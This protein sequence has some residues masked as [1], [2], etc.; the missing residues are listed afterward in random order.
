MAMVSRSVGEGAA[1]RGKEVGIGFGHGRD[2]CATA[3][4][5]NR[6]GTECH[7]AADRLAAW[8]HRTAF[9]PV[10]RE[11]GLVLCSAPGWRREPVGSRGR[12]APSAPP[13]QAAPRQ[14][15]PK[16]AGTEARARPP[17]AATVRR[18][19][20]PAEA[21]CR[22]DHRRRGPTTSRSGATRR[23][24]RSWSAATRSSAMA[25]PRSATCSSACPASPPGPAGP[26]RRD[27]HARPGQRLHADPARR[28]AR[29]AGLLARFAR[30]EQIE[31]IEILRAPTADRRTRDRRHHQHRHPRAAIRSA[32][33]ASSSAPGFE[34]GEFQPGLSWTRNIASGPFIVNWSLSAFHYDQDSGV[35]TRTV[36]HRL[37][38]GALTLDQL[39]P[40][41]HPCPRWR[42]PSHRPAAMAQRR[43]G[44]RRHADAERVLEPVRLSRR[45]HPDRRR[46]ARCRHRTTAS[47]ATATAAA[48]WPALTANGRIAW[49][50]NSR[51]ETRAGFRSRRASRCGC[52]LQAVRPLAVKTGQ[53]AA[54]AASLWTLSYG[55]GTSPA[56][57]IR[58]P[59]EW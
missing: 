29:T 13:R 16:P 42:R 47:T 9:E 21:R 55:A 59:S 5:V 45:R 1:Q 51:I 37:S 43:Q 38:D 31:R 24:R 26:R 35:S 56:V 25:T 4:S 10:W 18:K 28:R 32:S 52:T 30:A 23:R 6:A 41:D 3:R 46:R 49:P 39:A 7:G 8:P 44:R 53:R 50:G 36:D 20:R 22:P 33:T 27:P 12:S 11:G 15:D 14:G 34:K 2:S 57:W 40:S 48:R 19:A 58:V 17:T 54:A